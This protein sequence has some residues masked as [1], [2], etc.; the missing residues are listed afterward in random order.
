[1]WPLP[2]LEY[3]C[4]CVFRVGIYIFIVSIYIYIYIFIFQA[5]RLTF[6]NSCLLLTLLLP[7]IVWNM[8]KRL[9]GF[10]SYLAN[11]L[12]FLMLLNLILIFLIPKQEAERQKYHFLFLTWQL[13]HSVLI[14]P[15]IHPSTPNPLSKSLMVL[16]ALS[17]RDTIV[18][19]SQCYHVMGGRDKL[20]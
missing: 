9:Q 15:S 12:P 5:H 6:A 19:K 2:A 18:R 17:M 16:T 1:V 3:I 4:V 8:Y 13:C 11:N 14:N 10:S 7:P 20:G